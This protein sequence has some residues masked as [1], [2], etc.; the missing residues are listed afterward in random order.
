MQSLAWAKEKLDEHD[1]TS[2]TEAAVERQRF[3]EGEAPS[4]KN[5]AARTALT[6]YTV[7]C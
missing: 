1:K 5:H 6:S 4:A 7:R 3:S 2:A